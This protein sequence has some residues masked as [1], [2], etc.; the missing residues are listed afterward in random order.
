MAT[1]RS[2]VTWSRR[3]TSEEKLAAE[4]AAA[5]AMSDDNVAQRT[6]R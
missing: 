4:L 5:A 6:S 2:M 1:L 3:P